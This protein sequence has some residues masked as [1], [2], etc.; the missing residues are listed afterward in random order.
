MCESAGPS[1]P[2]GPFQGATAS[3][4][5]W[6]WAGQGCRATGRMGQV[7]I[8]LS[9]LLPRAPNGFRLERVPPRWRQE[10]RWGCRP[11]ASV[12]GN[13]SDQQGRGTW[14]R[15][16]YSSPRHSRAR[17]PRSLASGCGSRM[18]LPPGLPGWGRSRGLPDLWAWDRALHTLSVTQLVKSPPAQKPL[19]DCKSN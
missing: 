16:C 4:C 10:W 2:G 15:S 9:L 7:A 14:T 6:R 3:R 17:G 19:Q 13:P 8:L 5:G 1:T 18:R 12:E 11:G